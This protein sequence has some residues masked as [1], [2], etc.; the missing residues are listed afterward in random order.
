M[1]WNVVLHPKV[2]KSIA[3]LPAMVRTNL[4]LLL[5]EI[6]LS[7]PARGNWANYGKL[8]KD[9]HHC[10]LKKGKNLPTLLFGR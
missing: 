10:H 3:R 8:G 5:R 9:L 6:E 2:E 7:G 1:D 4:A